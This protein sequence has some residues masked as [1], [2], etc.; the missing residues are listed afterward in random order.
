MRVGIF[1]G[2]SSRE[3]EIS[4]AGGRTV[5][6][7]LDKDL[8]ESV[9]IFVDSFHNLILLNWQHIYKGSIRDFYPPAEFL[10]NSP[11]QFPI[12]LESL[13][14]LPEAEQIALMKE[15][16]KPIEIQDLK[17]AID[18]AF[19]ALHGNMGEDG[20]IQGLLEF[21]NI[22]YSGSGIRASSIGMDKAFQKKWMEKGGFSTPKMQIFPRETWKIQS[23]N[24]IVLDKI[25]AELSLPL[26]VRPANQGSSIGVAVVREAKDLKKLGDAAFFIR[27][28]ETKTWN[29]Y[30][31]EER[32]TY[33]RDLSDIRTGVGFPLY[34]QTDKRQTFYHPETLLNFLNQYSEFHPNAQLYLEGKQSERAIIFEQFIHGKEFSCVVL[35]DEQGNPIALPPTEIIKGDGVFDY[36]SKY[37]AGLSRKRTPIALEASKVDAI[38]VEC[39]RLFEYFEFNTYARID[40]FI[41]A[42]GEIVLNDPNTTSGMLPSSFFFHQAAEIGLNPSQLLTFIV[43]TSIQERIQASSQLGL[44]DDLLAQLD[45]AIE[46]KR[47]TKQHKQKVGILLGG[48]SSERHISLESGRNIYEKLASSTK[49]E[50]IP[51]FLTGNAQEHQ[52]Y[53]LPINL[54]LKDNAEDIRDEIQ[55]RQ[56]HPSL[57]TVRKEAN[58]IT[59]KYTGQ[60]EVMTATLLSYAELKA[61]VDLVFIAL[62]GRPGEDGAVQE[63]L[64][65]LGVPF[66]GSEASSA[67]VTIN[68]FNTLQ[69]LKTKGLTVTDQFL[70]RKESY[71]NRQSETLATVE[72]QFSYPLIAK[73]VDDGCSTAVKMIRNRTQLM[74]F[75]DCLF[76]TQAVLPAIAVET[77]KLNPKEEFP[78]KEEALVEALISASNAV[79]FLEIT[80]GLLTHYNEE[81][82]VRYEIF[83]PSEALASGEVLSLEEKFLAGAGQNITPARF[84]VPQYNIDYAKVSAQVRA[85][86]ETTAKTL[87]VTGYAR[88]DAFVRIYADGKVETIVIEVNALPGMTP[89]TCIFHQAALNAYK[90]YQFIDKI[91]EFGQK[92]AQRQLLTKV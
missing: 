39:K 23:Q 30:S 38:R 60:A 28:L 4:F 91:L 62:H 54:L 19:L 55:N 77:L 47:G 73:P 81:G 37:L 75:L 15:V 58:K 43:R 6:D 85:D 79:H 24:P 3:R 78:Q 71:L 68:K 9:L 5:Y 31:K 69:R 33:I 56:V 44:Y 89:A 18:F 86:L 25:A 45:Q 87:N 20:Q 41:K 35:K 88:I 52:L 29:G 90:P 48:Y 13:G 40:G 50:P 16:G 63:K 83:E 42:S 22:P 65:E 76:R 46:T 12:Y 53:H 67:Q 26:V 36:R 92:R 32:R 84:A 27:H 70:V 21:L 10:P 34:L 2:G 61:N 7:N 17:D 74:A 57:Q 8:F 59:E 11:H 49:Y 66:N 51:I 64:T 72:A 80:G 82:A 1:F 14:Q